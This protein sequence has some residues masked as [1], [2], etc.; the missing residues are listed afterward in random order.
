MYEKNSKDV[1]IYPAIFSFGSGGYTVTFPN[2]PG[3]ITQGADVREALAMAKEAMELYIF[4]LEEDNQKIPPPCDHPEKLKLPPRS[5][6]SMIE[7]WMPK[8]R[9]D[10]KREEKNKSEPPELKTP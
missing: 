1:Y 9:E 7:I 2:L 8:V 5:F 6:T 10:M 4:C 3:C